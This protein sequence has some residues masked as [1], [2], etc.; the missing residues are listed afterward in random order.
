M[1]VPF[2][3]LSSLTGSQLVVKADYSDFVR[4]IIY[5]GRP[6]RVLKS[7]YIMDWENNRQQEIRELTTKGIIPY[8]KDQEKLEQSGGS[9]TPAQ[10]AQ[11]RPWLM[12]CAA[13][14]ISDIKP[15]KGV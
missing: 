5:T 12:G 1:L 3:Q 10:M 6:M 14:A 13:G 15:A 2:A 4:T 11:L 9:V 8:T 7:D